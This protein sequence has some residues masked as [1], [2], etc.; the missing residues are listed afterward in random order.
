MQAPHTAKKRK[1]MVKTQKHISDLSQPI[2]SEKSKK[3]RNSIL[4]FLAITFSIALALKFKTLFVVAL[5]NGRPISSIQLNRALTDQFGAQTLDNLIS[6]TLIEQEMAKQNIVIKQ[7]QIDAQIEEIKKTLPPDTT[8]EQAI[9]LEGLNEKQFRSQIKLR[10]GIE[11][12]LGTKVQITD[13][14]TNSYIKEN[15]KFLSATSSAEKTTEAKNIIRN[16]KLNQLFQD[17][18]VEIKGKAKISN[19][20]AGKTSFK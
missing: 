13:E 18:I 3:S 9:A 5:V 6:Q 12:Y 8:L 15:D 4:V 7:D 1:T 2:G 10:L 17:W 20:L 14:E 11:T 16:Q 19:F